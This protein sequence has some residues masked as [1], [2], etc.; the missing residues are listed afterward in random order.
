VSIGFQK[1]ACPA[2]CY[3]LGNCHL[4]DVEVI[5]KYMTFPY[6]NIWSACS[7]DEAKGLTQ[8]LRQYKQRNDGL[9]GN[10]SYINFNTVMLFACPCL[11][12]RNI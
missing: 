12:V 7:T 8:R 3:L 10:L 2:C 11:C 6:C 4:Y 5:F 1:F 9:Y